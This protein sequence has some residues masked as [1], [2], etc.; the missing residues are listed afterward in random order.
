MDHGTTP[1]SHPGDHF[2]TAI[3]RAM[4][5]LEAF[6]ESHPELTNSQLAERTGLSRATTRRIILT[7]CDLGFVQTQDGR[8]F[9]L[10][11][12]VLQLGYSYL[13]SLPMRDV[14]RPH[15][16]T[17]SEKLS[18]TAGLAILDG[19]EIV[20]IAIAMSP[21][22]TSVRINLGTRLPAL[23]TAAGHVLLSAQP[24]E[25]IGEILHA[26]P[27]STHGNEA[28]LSETLQDTATRGW[29][30]VDRELDDNLQGAAAPIRDV[31]GTVVAAVCVSMHR[32]SLPRKS[33]QDLAAPAVL[34][35]AADIQA[36]L[37]TPTRTT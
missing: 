11:P 24:T 26:D 2:I 21:R 20:Y 12:R 6:G 15:L 16:E 19:T 4:S 36:E 14:A 5:V 37:G 1:S 7:L 8:S 23:T 31:H 29:A 28:T 18:E 17:L 25:R 35:T 34:R 9:R 3:A 30:V 33:M 27:D 10:T 32:G 13:A 22:L